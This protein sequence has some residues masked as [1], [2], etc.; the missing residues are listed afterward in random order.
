MASAKKKIVDA[1]TFDD[2]ALASVACGGFSLR[3]A[4]ALGLAR[5]KKT[6]V[7]RAD[8]ALRIP[9]FFTLDRF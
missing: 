6:D 9:P 8:D 5:G 1:V 2:R 7:A 3:D 4:V